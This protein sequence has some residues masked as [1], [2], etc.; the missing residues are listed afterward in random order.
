MI[1]SSAGLMVLAFVLTLGGGA[2][3]QQAPEKTYRIEALTR[4]DV[5]RI[6]AGL[7]SLPYRDAAPLIQKLQRQI[8]EQDKS[9]PSPPV[10]KPVQTPSKD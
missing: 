1:R 2:V 8:E 3:A 9:P 5:L 7:G 10:E 4:D 6:G